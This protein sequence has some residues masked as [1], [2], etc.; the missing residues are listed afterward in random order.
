M[1]T[2]AERAYFEWL[3]N[4]IEVPRTNPNTYLGLFTLMHSVEFQWTVPNDDNRKED[5]LYLRTEFNGGRHRFPFGATMLEVLIA[6]SRRVAFVA[7]GE[8]Q[9]WAWTLLEN[10]RLHKSSDPLTGHK[11]NRAAETLD[12][13]IWR[14]YQRDGRGGFFPL[15]RPIEDQTKIEIWAQMH[16]YINEMVETG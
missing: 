2:P 10:L 14:L 15:M 11:A 7:D 13:L 8:P 6:L 4:Q 9:V 1:A 3:I 12:K 16:A 5:A